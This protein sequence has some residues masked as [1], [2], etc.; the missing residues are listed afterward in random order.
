MI[1]I[2]QYI[3]ESF[4]LESVLRIFSKPTVSQSAYTSYNGHARL[5]LSYTDSLTALRGF[6]QRKIRDKSHAIQ[7]NVDEGT[8][9][10]LP[11][12]PEYFACEEGC[13]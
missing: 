1:H 12:P 13:T 4:E 3:V 2:K 7:R 8:A 11:C 10:Q 9:Q 5:Q 6:L